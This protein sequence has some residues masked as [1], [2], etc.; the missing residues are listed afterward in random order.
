MR[1][2]IAAR[3]MPSFWES[4]APETLPSLAERNAESI[5]ASVV[6]G[7]N[8]LLKIQPDVHCA[9]GVRERADGNKINTGLRDRAHRG[10]VHA[11]A[12][13][14]FAAA[15]ALLHRA[16]QLHERHVV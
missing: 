14:G 10:K 9:I 5:C 7:K 15:F 1:A 16:P 12:G 13:L 4:S 11:A 6:T 2:Q 3:L 8:S